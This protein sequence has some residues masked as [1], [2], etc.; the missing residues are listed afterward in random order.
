MAKRGLLIVFSGPSGVG[1]STVRKTFFAKEDLRL[2]YSISMTTRQ[3]REGERDGI[4]YFFVTKEQFMHAVERNELLEWAE[5]VGNL[6]GTPFAYV[7]QLRDQGL[8]VLLEIEVKGAEQVIHRIPDAV[9]IFLVPPSLEE[10]EKRIRGRRS[11]P[12]NII[13]Q[14]LTKAQYE[15]SLRSKYRHVVVN[16]DIDETAEEIANIIRSYI[17]GNNSN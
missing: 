8:N 17:Q 14:R 2:V 3:P 15:M 6:Y 5:F 16:K 10:L 7:N 9:T 1:K 12:E 13:Q 4:D 11:E